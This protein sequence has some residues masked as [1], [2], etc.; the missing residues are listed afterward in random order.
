MGNREAKTSV[1][2]F[3]IARRLEGAREVL[4][5]KHVTTKF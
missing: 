3:A 2:H 5:R 1:P 4:W